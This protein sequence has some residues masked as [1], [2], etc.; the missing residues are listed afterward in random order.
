M[1]PI[2]DTIQTENSPTIVQFCSSQSNNFATVNTFTFEVR[3]SNTSVVQILSDRNSNIRIHPRFEC[4]VNTIR[5]FEIFRALRFRSKHFIDDTLRMSI[6]INTTDYISRTQAT[7]F[8]NRCVSSS[9]KKRNT[10]RHRRN[11]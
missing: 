6:L 7:S 1:S 4:S 11:I 8:C 5:V 3:Y 10:F 9:E 2:G